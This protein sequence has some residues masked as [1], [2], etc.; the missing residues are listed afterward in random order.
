MIPAMKTPDLTQR[1]PRSPRVRLGGF[2]ILPRV[3]DKA[4][5]TLAGTNG[6]YK[7]NN[8]LD[9]VLFGFVGVSADEFLGQ[10]QAGAGDFDMLQWLNTTARKAPHE[11]ATW[12][13]WTETFVDHDVET[14]EWLLGRVQALDARRADIGGVFDYLNL[15]D[16]LSFGGQA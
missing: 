6:D 11:I 4:R 7:F 10:V 15:D 14:R 5:A 9:N 3:L 13:A 8:P 2:T 1:P 16:Y 12:S